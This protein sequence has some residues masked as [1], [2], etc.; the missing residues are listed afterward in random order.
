MQC[1]VSHVSQHTHLSL[2]LQTLYVM[3]LQRMQTNP[4]FAKDPYSYFQLAKVHGMPF[5]PYN[6]IV[7]SVWNPYEV[8][9]KRDCIFS[10]HIARHLA[11]TLRHILVPA[12]PK[13]GAL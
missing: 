5:G 10:L 12:M 1:C 13:R 4:N 7:S 3:A 6:S 11:G 8:C 2:L 9:C